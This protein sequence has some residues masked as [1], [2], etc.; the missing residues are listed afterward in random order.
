MTPKM[1]NCF[2]C[3]RELGIYADHDPLDT[4]GAAECEREASDIRRSE[5]EDAHRKLDEDRG[6]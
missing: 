2:Y 1:R 4:C 6:W 3:G 5:R